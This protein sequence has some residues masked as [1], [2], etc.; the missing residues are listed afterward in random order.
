MTDLIEYELRLPP[1]K[2]GERLAKT[3]GRILKHT[4]SARRLRV[5]HSKDDLVITAQIDKLHLEAVRG[6]VKMSM[7]AKRMDGRLDRGRP[8][9]VERCTVEADDAPQPA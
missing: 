2:A 5:Q 9:E 1:N 4:Y 6:A 8:R 7:M 3:V